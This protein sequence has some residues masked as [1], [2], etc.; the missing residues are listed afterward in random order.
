MAEM[1]HER[2]ICWYSACTCVETHSRAGVGNPETM[3]A[4]MSCGM[5]PSGSV[6]QFHKTVVSALVYL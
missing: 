2:M 3:I 4:A 6:A 5:S 1:R